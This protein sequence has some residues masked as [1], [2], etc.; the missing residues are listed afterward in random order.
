AEGM[1]ITCEP[2]LYISLSSDAPARYRGVGI[3]IE[4]DVLITGHGPE[5]LTAKVPKERAEIEA[6]MR[7]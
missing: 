4:D 2:G 1:V 3:R 5:V 7:G 6:L